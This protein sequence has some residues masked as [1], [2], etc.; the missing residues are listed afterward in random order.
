MPGLLICVLDSRFIKSR[1]H[2]GLVG[3]GIMG[4]IAIAGCVGL[5]SWLK[6]NHVESRLVSDPYDWTDPQF[7]GMLACFLLFGATY[8]GYQMCTEYTLSSTTVDPAQL[9]RVA[10]MFKFYSTF[11]MMIS[12]LLAGERVPFIGQASLQLA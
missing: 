9:A 5:M 3:M 8:A 12:F 4:T 10:G 11:G 1:R 6:V 7:G 2:R